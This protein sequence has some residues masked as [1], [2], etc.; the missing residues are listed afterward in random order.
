LGPIFRL[1]FLLY[2]YVGLDDKQIIHFIR[3]L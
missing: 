1:P 2:L 3:Y